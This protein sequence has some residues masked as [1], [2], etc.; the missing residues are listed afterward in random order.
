M[1]K[2]DKYR[3]WIVSFIFT[4]AVIAVYKTFD[5]LG[6]VVRFFGV[7]MKSLTPFVV[8]FVIAYILNIP[9][10]WLRGACEKSKLPVI[11][12]GSK[13]ISITSVYVIL[14]LL[15]YIIV[16]A[17]APAIY[18]NI[19][20]LYNNVPGYIRQLMDIV[21]GFQREHNITI[22][23]F[24]RENVMRAF[25]EI[26]SRIDITEFSKYAKGVV[27]ITASVVMYFIGII[28]SVYMLI[29][30]DKIIASSKRIA[31]LFLKE[32]NSERL[33]VK[34]KK[35]NK[36]FSKYI[37]CLL[38]DVL[39]MTVLAT[40]VL[41]LLNVKYA[42]ILGMM[43]GLFNLIPYF[44][45]IIAV[46]ITV[47][48][49]FLTGDPMQSLWVAISLLIVQQLDG[50]VIGPKIMGDVLDA[51]PLWII[52]AVTLGGGLFGV[53]GMIVSVPILITIKMIVTEYLDEKE[54]KQI[55]E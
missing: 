24:N 34:V 26:L 27:D 7:V 15:I 32:K 10:T 4:I 22:I 29:E 31:K 30:K 25:D 44:G 45:A 14:I 41:T 11:R 53:A 5:N 42:I 28:V 9:C 36:I 16:R 49:T 19:V 38:L 3:T 21:E 47:I 50:N 33:I 35:V 55:N 12:K 8:G 37:F 39:A 51:S 20:E 6:N 1:K 17:I 18:E 43:I 2:F 46:S 13:I 23:Q 40:T 52:F 54:K 48:I